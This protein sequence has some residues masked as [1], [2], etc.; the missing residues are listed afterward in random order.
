LL[1]RYYPDIEI[2]EF[3]KKADKDNYKD[4]ILKDSPIQ[5]KSLERILNIV[6]PKCGCVV[7]EN[8]YVDQDFLD[9][10]GAF[11]VYNFKESPK[12]CRRIHFFSDCI[13]LEDIFG[14][15]GING[16]EFEYNVEVQKKLNEH[17]DKNGK[18][19]ENYLGSTIIRPGAQPTLS[20]TYI[21]PSVLPKNEFVLCGGK[22][23]ANLYG[24]NLETFNAPYIQQDGKVSMCVTVSIWMATEALSLQWRTPNLSTSSITKIATSSDLTSGRAI[25]SSGLTNEQ[26]NWAL[27]SIG[28]DPIL[29]ETGKMK[30][31]DINSIIYTY[32][33][34]K[35]P[36]I[37]GIKDSNSAMMHAITVVGHGYREI[38]NNPTKR[39][40]EGK[41]KIEYCP[42][43]F[44]A[45]YFIIHDDSGGPYLYMETLNNNNILITDKIELQ[46][47]KKKGSAF[48]ITSM[49]IPLPKHIFLR[50]DEA[51]SKAL[52]IIKR[53]TKFKDYKIK[54]HVIR[55][56]L[57][58][59]NQFKNTLH[60]KY[61]KRMSQKLIAAYCGRTMSKYIWVSEISTF[62]LWNKSNPHDHMIKGEIIID[63]TSDRIQDD[64]IS[65]HF[66]GYFI[67]MNRED[68]GFLD[69][70][71][72][73]EIGNRLMEIDD[74]RDY[75]SIYRGP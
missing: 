32:V 2:E 54:D 29:I 57:M 53:L 43:N 50:G 37:L 16:E 65:I 72:K 1:E 3:R 73:R 74:D 27:D 38:T 19:K 51:E 71:E 7:E 67:F 5:N 26:M 63:A 9:S 17:R 70:I 24:A 59:S 39:M 33:E 61:R 69:I 52:S 44:W 15:E 36:V 14:C 4:K 46:K 68:S 56:F 42:S 48:K 18:Y 75:P 30:P 22:K 34:S 55:T 8:N 66:P 47:R 58:P 40:T 28:Y 41:T 25:P 60:K 11:Y 23:N 6:L 20:R 21:S 64:F 10:Y 13:K 49:T 12:I 31:I 62:P 45:P 35:I